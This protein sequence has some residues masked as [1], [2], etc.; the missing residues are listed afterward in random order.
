MERETVERPVNRGFPRARRS[1]VPDR[2]GTPSPTLL[3]TIAEACSKKAKITTAPSSVPM[4]CLVPK[5]KQP[6]DLLSRSYWTAL[7]N[8]LDN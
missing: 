3:S 2:V 7:L 5:T 4:I 1:F 8:Y 6:Q